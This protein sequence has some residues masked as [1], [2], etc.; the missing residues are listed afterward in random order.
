MAILLF[1]TCGFEFSEDYYK[2]IVT[3]VP[4]VSLSLTNFIDG[5]TLTKPKNINYN[6]TASNKNKLYEIRFYIND[7]LIKTYEESN[8]IFFLDV[9][10]LDNG[11]YKLKVEYFFKTGTESLAEITGSEVYQIIEEFNFSIDKNAKPINITEIEHKEGT[12]FIHFENYLFIDEIDKSITAY[13]IVEEE[14]NQSVSF[15]RHIRLSKEDVIKGVFNDVIASKL[16]LKYYTKV[17]NYYNQIDSQSKEINIPD[18]FKVEFEFINY[19]ELKLTWPEHP[20]YTNVPYFRFSYFTN[21]VNTG[22]ALSTKKGESI[23][24]NSEITFG[25]A[26][27]YIIAMYN[28]TSDSN[29]FYNLGSTRGILHIGEYF[30]EDEIMSLNFNNPK[31]SSYIYNSVTDKI[32]ALEVDQNNN[33]PN[34]YNVYIHQFNPNNLNLEKTSLITKTKGY[35][36][37]LNT[38]SSGNLILDLNEKSLLL[39]A[40]SL[41]I[42]KEFIGEDYRPLDV[43]SIVRH[44]GNKVIID[45]NSRSSIEEI[46]FYDAVNKNLIYKINNHDATFSISATGEY[47][48]WRNKIYHFENTSYTLFYDNSDIINDIIFNQNEFYIAS[49]NG[50]FS[51]LN[52]ITKNKVIISNIPNI[53]GLKHD[54][55]NNKILIRKT[56]NVL[57]LNDIV[58]YDFNNSNIKEL[59]VYDSESI[60]FLNNIILSS[61][62]FYLK[63]IF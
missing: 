11:E 18:T 58:L 21:G 4:N 42:D 15:Q 14:N 53:I 23:L 33:Y 60:Y 8:G 22:E 39:N 24:Q 12:I 63:N 49:K 36:G 35:L 25:S 20:L 17:E 2:D 44:R 62:G 51:V 59:K 13:L 16:N 57:N 45:T 5:E 32:Y 55:I 46:Y 41:S 26:Y 43:Y 1:S 38:N 7:N 34:E 48:K 10:N 40:T 3:S 6:Y 37:D 30:H 50:D 61:R 54:K 28:N 31:Y 56:R 47:F 27:E 9:E 29:I 19:N 52:P